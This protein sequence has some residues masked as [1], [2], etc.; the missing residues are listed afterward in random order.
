MEAYD[1]IFGL[2]SQLS[3]SETFYS[4][5]KT[6]V[7]PADSKNIFFQAVIEMDL[8]RTTYN[9]S[10]YTIWNCLGDIGGLLDSLKIIGGLFITLVSLSSGDPL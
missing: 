1:S 2:F 7:Q 9:R 4:I 6:V 3:K 5:E 8:G 10:V